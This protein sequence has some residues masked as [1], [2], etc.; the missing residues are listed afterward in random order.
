[1][2]FISIIYKVALMSKHTR[3]NSCN[4]NSYLYNKLFPKHFTHNRLNHIAEVEEYKCFI[5]D[6][7]FK[8]AIESVKYLNPEIYYVLFATVP[9][10]MATV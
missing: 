8:W 6:L 1:M 5:G 7:R 3:M 10:E 2:Y 9:S 4:F